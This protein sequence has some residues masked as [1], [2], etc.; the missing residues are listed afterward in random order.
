M[1]ENAILAVQN[2]VGNS[3]NVFINKAILVMFKL[4]NKYIQVQNIHF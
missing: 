3:G 4:N 1:I 2:Y